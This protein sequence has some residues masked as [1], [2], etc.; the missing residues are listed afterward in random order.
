MQSLA[1]DAAGA[2]APAADA[3]GGGGGGEAAEASAGKPKMDEEA[4][5]V[6]EGNQ[7]APKAGDARGVD[8]DAKGSSVAPVKKGQK[9]TLE[10]FQAQ[11]A[12]IEK[13]LEKFKQP[14]NENKAKP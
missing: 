3:G 1:D 6:P 12:H 9:A 10:D 7:A 14:A 2:Q 5:E 11:V 8:D 4:A 13:L